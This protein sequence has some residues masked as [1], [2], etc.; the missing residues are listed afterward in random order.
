[1]S[2]KSIIRILVESDDESLLK[3]ICDKRGMTQISLVSRMVK[4]LA[5]QDARIQGDILNAEPGDLSKS[6][7]LVRKLASFSRLAEKDIP[8]DQRRTKSR[9]AR[10]H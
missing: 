7:N 10:T 8:I 3:A 5:R 6:L 2:Q 9:S 1:M 4:W